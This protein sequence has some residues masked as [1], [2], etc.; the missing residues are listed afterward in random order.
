[1]FKASA[2][3]LAIA[4][5]L[6][7]LAIALL[8]GF[9][10]GVVS[11]HDPVRPLLGALVCALGYVWIAGP[12]GVRRD[13]RLHGARLV[14]PLAI[15]IAV[16]A[17]VAGL[18]RNTWT[19]GGA[20]SYAYVSQADRWVHFRLKTP[21]P[22]SSSAPWPDAAWTFSPH[23]YRPSL[24]GA[25]L[26]PVTAP[27]LPLMMAAAKLLAGHA[28]MFWVSPLCGALLVWTTFAIGRRLGSSG[29]GLIAAWLLA[30]SP[31]FLAM[32]VSPMSDVPAAA[33]WAVALCFALPRENERAR[34]GGRARLDTWLCGLAGAAA[35][36]IRPN[37]AP[38]AIICAI[39]IRPRLAAQGAAV[40]LAGEGP[41]D[42]GRVRLNAGEVR[43]KPDATKVETIV[44][45][46]FSRTAATLNRAVQLNPHGA[47]A[48]L[49]ACLFIGWLN[50]YL[51]GSPLSSGYG[52]VNTLFSAGHIATNLHRYGAWLLESQTPLAVLG[53]VALVV[54][55][56]GLWPTRAWRLA[57]ALMAFIV[58][59]V[60]GLYLIYAPFDAW[61][62]LRFLLPAWPAMCL[63]SAAVL[64]SLLSRPNLAIRALAF[65]AMVGVGVHGLVY[66][67]S[68]GA[69]PSGEG[70]HRY[71][72]VGKLTA[73]RTEASSVIIAGQNTGPTRYYGGR[74]TMRFD[75]LDAAWLDRAA[76]WLDAH[77]HHPYFLLE[78][79]EIP[80]FQQRFASG[81]RLGAL[82]FAPVMAYYA[83]GVPGPVYLF[84]P[85]R[86]DGSTARPSPPRSAQRKCVE[87][88]PEPLLD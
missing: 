10:V 88:S 7:A 8:G 76:A 46:G 51:Y 29:I 33:F 17:A 14:A 12:A 26:V 2:A 30:T 55:M 32:I 66:A 69:F 79:W 72:S 56:R 28:A 11:A 82:S 5:T 77:G 86:P 53:L 25:A 80:M 44:A 68:H 41:R 13:V 60:W 65:A 47:A 74:M 16:S 1:M 39:T 20:D 78:E 15:L 19:A 75:L 35:I 59:I 63:G 70:D 31:V 40:P 49:V 23:G 4:G 34:S 45:S 54:P 42:A 71:A 21:V 22:M 48:V 67:S 27:G 81:N 37:L 36:L 73:E 52:G 57:A 18:A 84:D 38:L 50:N 64:V 83:P 6:W 9:T 85:L 61:W 43:L 3:A 87:P 62:Y 24:D 58:A